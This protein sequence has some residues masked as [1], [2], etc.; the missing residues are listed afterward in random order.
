MREDTPDDSLTRAPIPRRTI[1]L[2]GADGFLG[3]NL[4]GLLE[5]D[6]RV[7]RIVALDVEHPSTAG[8]KT[9]FYKVD[10]TQ[11]AVDARLAE[12]L[13]AEGVDT[14][15]HMAFLASPTHH[16]AWAHELESVG[17]MHVL[18]ACR[19]RPVRKF[20]LWSQTLLYGAS[21]S[22]PNF[23]PESHPLEAATQSRFLRDKV[24]AE[25][26]VGRFARQL[27]STLVT[28]LRLAPILGP[29][30][31]NYVT[32]Y[33]GRRLVPTLLGFDPLVQFLHEVDALAAFKLAVVRDVPGT[34]NI[35]GDGVLPLSTVI[36]LAG[37]AA[38][39]VPH[40]LAPGLAR[41][42]WAA[43]LSE[44][45]PPFVEYLRWLCVADG[46]LAARELGFR[47]AFSTRE[48]VLDYASAQHLRDARLL[49]PLPPAVPQS[50]P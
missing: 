12:I 24:E 35:V 10:L 13:H 50:A 7:G 49:R 21:P 30:V 11:P 33:L 37:R 20:V 8:R 18:T 47:P 34:Y 40:P 39:P 22:N 14:L 15:L 1:A 48:A 6:D 44:A 42:L 32:R 4:V 43:Q 29:T 36:R 17:T 9:R 28:T 23:L 31:N 19:E 3:R 46:S 41:A 38:L 27:P 25:E 5:D 2:T 16:G 26:A 45:P